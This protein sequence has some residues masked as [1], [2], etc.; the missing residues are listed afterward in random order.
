MN[1]ADLPALLDPVVN[2]EA[3]YTKG[4]RL[5]TGDAFRKIPK[6]R[7]FGNAALYC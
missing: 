5:V 3:D 2:N 7:Y 4:N 6:I 1:P